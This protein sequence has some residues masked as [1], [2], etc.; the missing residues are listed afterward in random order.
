MRRLYFLVPD[1]AVGKKV[2]DEL[3]LAHVE[4]KHIHVVGKRGT[5]LEDLPEA[6]HW[7]K[8][9]VVP[10]LQRA[11]P[12]GGATG[13]LCGL[14]AL[15]LGPE[16]VVAGGGVLLATSLA[17]VGIGAYLGGMVGLNVENTRHKAFHDAIERGELLVIVDVPRERVEEIT[18]RIKKAHPEAEPEGMDPRVFP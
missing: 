6:S 4:W 5:P 2:V 17:G 13:L 9:D 15:A 14:V 16:L 7:Q 8:S 12:I 11:V 1:V 10:A 18:D 3:L